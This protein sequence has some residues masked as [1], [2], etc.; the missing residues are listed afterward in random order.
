MEA[1]ACYLRCEH[2]PV[3]NGAA[4][5]GDQADAARLLEAD[6]L[7]GSSLR[8]HECSRKVDAHHVVGILGR[9]LKCRCLL[10]DAGCSNEA[11]QAA[12]GVCDALKDAVELGNVSHVALVVC[13]GGAEL[14]SCPL[15]DL[16]E[17]RR[18]VVGGRGQPIN[19]MDYEAV[20]DVWCNMR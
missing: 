8:R 9:E 17:A 7:A 16:G 5:A 1:Y 13:E 12:G 18:G 11:I 6:H 15:G 3:G 14:L 20:N 10:V 4:H 19:G 2:T